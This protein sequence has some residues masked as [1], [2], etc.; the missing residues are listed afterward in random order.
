MESTV[1]E[2]SLLLNLFSRFSFPNRDICAL[3]L[4]CRFR[5]AGLEAKLNLLQNSVSDS[6]IEALGGI[7]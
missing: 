7:L 3:S 5:M 6:D 4:G 2:A 1:E